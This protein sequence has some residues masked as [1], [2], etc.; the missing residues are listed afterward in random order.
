MNDEEY[1]LNSNQ[2]NVTLTLRRKPLTAPIL[3]T[4][5]KIVQ[6]SPSATKTHTIQSSPLIFQIQN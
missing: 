1:R 2:L 3:S 4:I 5:T 6:P